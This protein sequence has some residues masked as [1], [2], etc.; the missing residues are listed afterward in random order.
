MIGDCGAVNIYLWFCVLRDH[1]LCK[2]N[3][4][5]I[6]YNMLPLR[7]MYV[8]LP[9]MSQC[10]ILFA[11]LENALNLLSQEGCLSMLAQSTTP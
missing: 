8:R 11:I 10:I 1:I 5:D 2:K 9:S 3:V 7:I 4:R 6:E